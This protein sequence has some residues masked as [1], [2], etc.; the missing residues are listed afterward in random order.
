MQFDPERYPSADLNFVPTATLGIM[1][2]EYEQSQFIALL[3]TLGPNT[4][5]MP[6]IL[7]GI[8]A[9]SSLSNRAEL[10]EA[11]TKMSQPDPQA[12]EMQQHMGQ[13]EQLQQALQEGPK[14]DQELQSGM[15]QQPQ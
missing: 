5:V 15:A 4:P 7:K 3:Q 1:A 8:I 14:L 6:L 12:Q 11:L 13:Q 10:I 2:R 9:N